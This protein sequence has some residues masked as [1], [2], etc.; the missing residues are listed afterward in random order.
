M[1]PGRPDR[2]GDHNL[3]MLGAAW[4]KTRQHWNDDMTRRFDTDHWTPLLGESRSYLAALHKLM[5]LLNAAERDT[6]Y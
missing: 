3:R 6:E 2:D 5:E 1:M 4:D